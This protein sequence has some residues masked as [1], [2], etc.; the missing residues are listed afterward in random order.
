MQYKY[1][2][3]Y[4][5]FQ[6]DNPECT[7]YLYFPL[8]N[9]NG[10]MSCV[11]PNLGG[12]SK[13]DQ[14][15]FYLEPVSSENLHISKSTRNFWLG[16]K[17]QEPWSA[18]GVSTRQQMLL[19]S[20]EKEETSLEA[21]IMWHTVTRKNKKLGLESKITSFVPG[22]GDTVELME[23]II[24]N[25][26][27]VKIEFSPTAAVPIYGRSA[28]NIR[29]HRQVTSLLHR[30]TTVKNGV[31]VNPTLSFDERGHKVNDTLYGFFAGSD[32]AVN[33][34]GFF[35][36]VAE[37]IG[38]GGSLENPEAIMTDRIRPVPSGYEINGY[39]ALGGVRFDDVSL[40]RGEEIAF[41]LVLGY[42]KDESTLRNT[43]EKYLDRAG[44]HKA[45][46]ET[47]DLWREKINV[48]LETNNPEF[49]NWMYWVT[50][51]PM[52]RRIYGCSFLP[53][54]DYGKGG[55]GWRDLW[56]DCL[57][58]LVMNP[59]GV[60]EMLLNN[61]SGIRIDGTNAT[62]IGTRPGEFIADR[63]NI[64]RVWMDHGV[65]PF[66]TTRLYIEQTGDIELLLEEREYFRDPQINRG[67]KKDQNWSTE[68]GNLLL[69]DKGE[70]YKGSILEHILVQNLTSFY[71]VGEHNHIRLRGADWNDALDM[72]S[73]RG[74]SVAFTAAYASNLE[75]IAYMIK[76][77]AQKTGRNNIYL[78]GELAVLLN[79][80]P[81]Y[82]D[83]ISKKREVLDEYCN[84]CKAY[85]SGVKI[86]FDSSDLQDKLLRKSEWIKNHIREKEWIT[87]S[88]GDSW[89]NG[90]YDNNGRRVEG[91]T[92][93]G[94]RMM[95]TSQVFTVMGGISSAEQTEEIIKAVD[96]YLYSAEIGGYR[97][98]TDFHEVKT[99]LGRMFGFA[100]GHKE[101]GAVFSH[102]T[103]M[104][105]YGLYKR[106]FVK[107]G[108]KAIDSLFRHLGN[109]EKSRVYP[110]ITEYINEKGEGMYHYLTGSA[111]WLLLTVLTQMYGIKGSSGNLL[112]EPKI[113]LQ[114]F[115]QEGKASIY[116]VFADKRLKITYCNENKKE[117]DEY[118]I[119]E[120][121]VNGISIG[122]GV[123]QIDRTLI[124]KLSADEL[125]YICVLLS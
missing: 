68:D 8:A 105:A 96:K 103:I 93:Q 112:F 78:A 115:N 6:L 116:C 42:G 125:N 21:G 89:F 91:E 38:N 27:T 88:Q 73:Q 34:L 113:L 66:I 41:Y 92:P 32:E 123:N 106:G 98:N 63:N 90:Y 48:M 13:L 83:D 80:E 58:L 99:D 69:T 26:G 57:A 53:H 95:L 39:E 74:E 108:F 94:I 55:R 45:L 117:F 31:I 107:E 19:F 15:H 109:F 1:I 44:F 124:D 4:G 82:Y 120:I 71:D 59:N 102:M 47:K 7:N 35:P 121:L 22:N 56:Q 76:L 54:H 23:V 111:S 97:L 29:D 114:Q 51:Q 119:S 12:D 20:D 50:F 65:W 28:D 64:T 49:N 40:D 16:V 37:Y 5:T 70:V 100:Y 33:I 9:E 60:R 43:A 36:T 84:L 46:E 25:Q 104:Y 72:A 18:T 3:K 81:K 86:G 30:I 101:N 110:G 85:V 17:G 61:F 14:H 52:L 2:D 24:S 118:K 11:T 67:E 79:L 77:L 62:I 87:T 122:K 75:E 10:V